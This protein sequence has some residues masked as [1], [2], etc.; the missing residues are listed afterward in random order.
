MKNFWMGWSWKM[1]NS[2]IGWLQKTLKWSKTGFKSWPKLVGMG[3]ETLYLNVRNDNL[4]RE[5]SSWKIIHDWSW[6]SPFNSDSFVGPSWGLICPL[7]HKSHCTQGCVP[8]SLKEFF[9]IN[10]K[11]SIVCP[12]IKTSEYQLFSWSNLCNFCCNAHDLLL[13]L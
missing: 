7:F 13:A 3:A 12:M 11:D 10:P 5:F 2:F 6:Q 9:I 4:K 8:Q 1:G